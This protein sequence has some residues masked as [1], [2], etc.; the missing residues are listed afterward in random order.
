MDKSCKAVATS[1][2]TEVRDDKSFVTFR[3]AVPKGQH[4]VAQAL[5]G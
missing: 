5:A 4:Y 3:Y 1:S 2:C